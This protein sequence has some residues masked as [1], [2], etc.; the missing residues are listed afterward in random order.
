MLESVQEVDPGIL[1]ADG[2]EDALI[3]I[4]HQFGR[5]AVA[6]YD[7]DKVIEILM[8]QSMTHEEAVEF[9]EFNIVGAWVGEYTPVFIALYENE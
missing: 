5:P 7:Y 9:F 8:S 4:C 2:L 6:A 3:G 1:Q